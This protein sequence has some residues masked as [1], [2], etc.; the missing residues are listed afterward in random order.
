MHELGVWLAP[1]GAHAA[2]PAPGAT[3]VE[4][5]VFDGAHETRHPLT[6]RL[7]DLFHGAVPLSAGARYGFRAH[8]PGLDPSKLLLDPWARRLETPPAL[9]STQFTPGADSAPHVP[10]CVLDTPLPALEP[11]A[12][13]GP[14]VIYE[15]HVRGFTRL[16]H[17][18]PA[19]LRGTFAGLAHPAAIA[20]LTALG[21]T[22][23][24][25]MPAAAWVDERHLPPLGLS[26]YWGYNP[27]AFLAPD[28]RLAPG[29]MAEVRAAVQA[30]AAA[31]IG[32]IFDVVLNHT[33][34]SDAAGPTLS[35]RGL[36]EAH[37]YRMQGGV[38]ANDAG[39]GNTL[40][41]DKPWPLRLAIDALRH[42]ATQTGC[43]GFRL[44]LATTLGRRDAGFDPHAPLLLAMRQDPVL[45]RLTIIAEPWDVGP[46]GHRLGQFPPGWGE[47][48]DRFRDDI[49]RFWRG[50]AG[51]LGAAATR[52]AGS[53]DV[54]A[55]RPA[56]DSVNFIA[57]HDGFTLADLLAFTERRNHANGE[58]NR[59]GN[60]GEIAWNNGAEGQSSDPA[61]QARRAGLARALLLTL[62]A[63]RGTPMLGMGDELGRTQ[64]GNNN[65]Y[66]QDNA[67]SWLDW[68]GADH[69]L[70][71]FAARLIHARRAHPALH[72]AQHLTGAPDPV[73][74][75]PDVAW[76]H[77]GG[78]A[79]DWSRD[80][81]LVA[82]LAHGED[83]VAVALNAGDDAL[84]L[85]LPAPR[86]GHAWALLADSAAPDNAGAVPAA[87]PPRAVLLLAEHR[88][89]MP[90]GPD[91]DDT[92]TAATAAGIETRWR[93][94]AGREHAVPIPTLR[95]LL[96]ALPPPVPRALPA[97]VV[98]P[99]E[100]LLHGTPAAGTLHITLEDGD[101][102]EFPLR[103]GDGAHGHT[104]LPD[105]RHLPHRRITLPALPH[106]LHRAALGDESALLVCAPPRCHLPD[107]RGFGVMA[108]AWAL[109]RAGDGG[110]GDYAAVAALARDARAAGAWLLGISPP[111]ALM[112]VGRERA[113]P[114]Q[115]SDRRFLEPAL[116][117]LPG[118]PD[119]RGDLVDYPAVWAAKRALLWRAFQAASA[120]MPEGALLDFCTHHAIA[121]HLGHTDIARWPA[122]LRHARDTAVAGF[123]AAHAEAIRFHAFCQH[124]ADAQLA[125][126][127]GLLYRDLAVGAHPD[128]AEA[129]SQPV[130]FLRGFSLGAPPDPLGPQGQVWGL[131]AP[132]PDCAAAQFDALLAANMRHAA[133][134]R[135]DHV[136]GVQRLFLVPDG[137]SG[138]DGAYLRYP[139][140][141][142]L[143]LLRLHS[144]RAQCLVV[145]E[146]LGTVPE[147]L[148]AALHE[149]AVL[150]YRVLPFQRRDDGTPIP[151]REW[152]A[153]A[154]ACVATH[155]TPTLRGWWE[156]ADIAE[157]E[158]L[159]RF[160]PDCRQGESASAVVERA[161]HT[162]AD[163][164]QGDRALGLGTPDAR[165]EREAEKAALAAAIGLDA[166]AP[167]T[168]AL[169]AAIHRF[170]AEGAAQ[171]LLV[172]AEDLA[173]ADTAVNLPGTDRERPNWR[174]RLPDTGLLATPYAAAILAALREAGR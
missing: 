29:G 128:G 12:P 66:A 132:V 155:D 98:A 83:R 135:V 99:G 53:A 14:A 63:A 13:A 105:G 161:I 7:G 91:D 37:W 148:H 45:R 121:E 6:Q 142:M 116:I 85:V 22:H 47:W 138:A 49:R 133:A 96:A 76:R 55:G 26:N 115:A 124:L 159:Q 164:S 71:R 167:Y 1:G 74:G 59:D 33:G 72:A 93:D 8:G 36:G 43:A 46:G 73:T 61:V 78:G 158:A 20:H 54:F 64:H 11:F 145:G 95:A 77:P 84:P 23:V 154:A 102:L 30:L 141:A 82:L 52:L 111:H 57:A 3:R 10:R 92:R 75:L 16:H 68:A 174:R 88:R 81:A 2:I 149:S 80:A 134:L 117:A 24:E 15:L 104:V 126:A 140:D 67:T 143:A 44:D 169:A 56:T 166:T 129:W 125:E 108:Q 69:D 87:L 100:L 127:S 38:L 162:L 172:Q 170:V 18:V 157:R 25:L 131:P 103:E 32:T 58:E 139:R 50:D 163:S 109:R 152:P 79:P 94:L 48:N 113:S 130:G 28:P 151:P 90:H 21:I 123:V 39:T 106:G 42:W 171:L 40:A 19:E 136:M 120:P 107:R 86:A 27:V 89:R 122:G 4:L 137:A 62:M 118:M 150:S 41:L 110:I 144:T 114:Y 112:P 160:H 165:A 65:A 35:L 119:A 97:H 51:I 156:G 34:E 153:Q 168:P 17:G 60:A 147:G 173:G 101:T 9:H 70:A 31:G 146:D 5:C